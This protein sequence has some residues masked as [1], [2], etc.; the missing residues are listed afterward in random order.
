MPLHAINTDQNLIG[1]VNASA[2]SI[3]H[4][5]NRARIWLVAFILHERRTLMVN[6]WYA[7]AGKPLS[8]HVPA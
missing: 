7:A 2:V 5:G 1:L 4:F 6:R 3:H 8:R